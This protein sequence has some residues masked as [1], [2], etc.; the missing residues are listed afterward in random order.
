[1]KFEDHNSDGPGDERSASV[2]IAVKA[3]VLILTKALQARGMLKC[4]FVLAVFDGE[5]DNPLDS[6]QLASNLP[7]EVAKEFLQV[8]ATPDD[9]ERAANAPQIIVPKH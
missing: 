4:G 2:N 6:V 9:R 8:L 1:M 7:K 5:R 3:A